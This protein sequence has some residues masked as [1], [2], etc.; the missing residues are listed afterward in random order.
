MFSISDA[1]KLA[2]D[3]PDADHFIAGFLGKGAQ[4]RILMDTGLMGGR[5]SAA[6][7]NPCA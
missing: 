3:L 5:Y 7:Q 4:V 1:V 6:T 2:S